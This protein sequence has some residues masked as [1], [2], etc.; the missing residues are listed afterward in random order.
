[1]H[2]SIQISSDPTWP[3]F[4]YRRKIRFATL[5]TKT[6][7]ENRKKTIPNI[8]RLTPAPLISKLFEANS[9]ISKPACQRVLQEV[10]AAELCWFPHFF[11]EKMSFFPSV[12]VNSL[13]A[14]NFNCN[15]NFNSDKKNENHRKLRLVHALLMGPYSSSEEK[16][17]KFLSIFREPTFYLPIW[18]AVP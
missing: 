10:A 4:S 9:A 11:S 7:K 14:L 13:F 17:G 1:M 16:M 3:R 5:L 6:P 15:F 2:F 18:L 12:L 8:L